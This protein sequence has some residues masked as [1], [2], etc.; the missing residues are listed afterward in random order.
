MAFNSEQKTIGNKLLAEVV[1]T[2]PRNQ[3]EYVWGEKNWT[4][5]WNDI[6]F[7]QDDENRSHFIGS[8]VLMDKEEREGI[9]HYDVIDGQQRIMTV[10]LLVASIMQSYKDRNEDALYNGLNRFLLS[11][12]L[13]NKKRCKILSNYQPSIDVIVEKT[14]QSTDSFDDICKELSNATDKKIVECYAY[15]YN[16]LKDLETEELKQF[17]L[18]LL[19]TNYINITA[20]TEEDSYTIFEILNARGMVLEDSELLKNF[21]MRYTRPI[22]D[23]DRVKNDWDSY[24]VTPLGNG[25]TKYLTHYVRHKYKI[26]EKKISSYEVIKENNSATTVTDLFKDLKKKAL[27]YCKIYK[28]VKIADGGGCS[29][30]EY[31]VFKFL[32]AYKGELFRPVLLSL[33]H[34][35]EEKQIDENLY[36]TTLTFL[37]YF[38]TCYNLIS[39]ETSNKIQSGVQRYAF[40]LESKYDIIILKEFVVYLLKRLPQKTE[41]VRS[42]STLGWSHCNPAYNDSSCKR[43]VQIALSIIELIKSGNENVDEFTIEHL[44]P[45]SQSDNNA[46][47]GNLLPLEKALNEK[48]KDKDL[49]DKIQIY[50]TSNFRFARD[51]ADQYNPNEFDTL[52]RA[53]IMADMIYKELIRVSDAIK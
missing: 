4:E 44:N 2:I 52:K 10:L 9:Q 8:V 18:S 39:Q 43:K 3:R 16:K 41:F 14:A 33:M 45:D 20:T 5:L 35:K 25:L 12:D 49:A 17:Q 47:I 32:K 53:R 37:Q 29:N 19:R 36:K 42:F 24:F 34:A 38:F 48:C 30:V 6:L 22:A 28:P 11:T 40:Q 1:Y 27:Y 13:Q 50:R 15:F 21:I 23:V 46:L 26:P 51:F 31:R 7:A